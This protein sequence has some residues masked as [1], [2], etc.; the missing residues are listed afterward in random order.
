MLG[1]R[2]FRQKCE[3]ERRY[4][5]LVQSFGGGKHLHARYFT[6]ALVLACLRGMPGYG[7]DSAGGVVDSAFPRFGGGKTGVAESRVSGS[8]TYVNPNNRNRA[9]F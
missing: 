6:A 1:R 4:Q 7:G 8:E 2:D 9:P 5:G 3:T